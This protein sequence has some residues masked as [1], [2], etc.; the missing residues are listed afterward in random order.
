MSKKWTET[1]IQFLK[2]NYLIMTD[3]EMAE[4]L[5]RSSSAVQTK[6]K[7][8][9]LLHP[10]VHKKY[11]FDDV[12]KEFNKTDYIL[13]STSDEYIN[14]GKNNLR[15]ICPQHK[16]KGELTISLS[17]LQQ[18]RGCK[19]CGREKVENAHIVDLDINYHRQICKDK[20]FIYIESLRYNGKISIKFICPKHEE[21]G[22]QIMTVYNM[23]REIKGCKYCCGKDLP[24]WYVEQ[25]INEINPYA[26]I[27]GEYN[28]LTERTEVKCLKHNYIYQC[29]PQNL[30]QGCGCYYCG[31]EKSSL[32][33]F[34]SEEKVIDN[35]H[36]IN[37]HIDLIQY[38]GSARMSV[39]YC[40]IHNKKFEKTYL[41]LIQRKS[42]C[43]LCYSD[44]LRNS[45]GI[46]IDEFKKRLF[47]VHP[48]IIV[49]GDYVN[50][51]TP[52]KMYCSLHD[53]Y[54][55]STPV[56][57]LKRLRCCDKSRITY[58]EEQVCK[59]LESWGYDI[60]RQKSFNDCKDQRLL[61][62]DIYLSNY[63][64]VIEYQGEQH[65]FPIRYSSETIE[66]AEEKL[67]YTQYHDQLKYD[68]CIKNHIHLIYVPY[69]E[70]EDLEYYLFNEL[71]KLKIIEE[72]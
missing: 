49:C 63:N 22:E 38:N 21:L 3:L 39:F 56:D 12:V 72:V 70:F 27:L 25:K 34:N 71:V 11:S 50:N 24:Q 64:T 26:V 48:E 68:Y 59:L 15:Y 23:K 40:K 17:H 42:G 67:K 62:Y 30:L 43:D 41:S 13:L 54:F 18:G 9:G 60:E 4:K 55:E 57:V 47:S 29:T 1:E 14:C 66:E 51:S 65:Y 2:D 58:K 52:I 8:I 16:D 32:S 69:Y 45:Q 36:R 19:Y 46:G 31:K 35:I 37:P 61:F 44:N 5:N 6:R 20:G 53:Y 33:S 10:Q 7:K 28:K